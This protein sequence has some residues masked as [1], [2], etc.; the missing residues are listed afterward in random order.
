MK[1]E[2]TFEKI[3][4]LRGCYSIEKVHD[5]LLME[6]SYSIIDLMNL[7]ISIEDKVWFVYNSCKLTIDQKIDLAIILG[8]AVVPI[9]ND[10]YPNDNRVDECWE[11]ID[12]FRKGEITKCELLE[13]R[14]H[15]HSAV[16]S[17]DHSTTDATDTAYAA[18]AVYMAYVATYP[19]DEAAYNAYVDARAYTAAKAAAYVAAYVPT[20][21]NLL[22]DLLIEFCKNN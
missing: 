3:L 10:K 17:T 11:A 22:N 12:K 16:Y 15:I 21:S 7:S 1:K 9:Y 6:K 20:Y 18:Y 8:K 2:F 5:L 19:N 13:K 4:K 14:S